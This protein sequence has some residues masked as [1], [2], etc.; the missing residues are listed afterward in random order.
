VLVVLLFKIGFPR[1]PALA[2]AAIGLVAALL[3]VGLAL[4]VYRVIMNRPSTGI[5][6]LV[7]LTGTVVSSSGS[8]GK[9]F[10][11]GE[12]WDADFPGEADTGDEVR[13]VRVRGLRL[14]VERTGRK[15]DR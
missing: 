3:N 13:V 4:V 9:V 10:L 8:R 14:S 15:S 11:R 2:W 7:G 5:E 1:L 12:H 6:G